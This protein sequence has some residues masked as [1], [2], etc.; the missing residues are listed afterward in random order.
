MAG[1]PLTA[2]RARAP[3]TSFPAGKG[4]GSGG[5]GP[6][7]KRSRQSADGRSL[8][9]VGVAGGKPSRCEGSAATT[10]RRGEKPLPCLNL[11]INSG[12]S[13]CLSGSFPDQP[14]VHCPRT[15]CPLPSHP[16]VRMIVMFGGSGVHVSSNGAQLGGS[17]IGG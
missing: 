6:D 14:I 5:Q 8:F 7:S 12:P 13:N 16:D 15:D 10:C 2:C 17:Q 4:G 1:G 11:E 9:R 3:E